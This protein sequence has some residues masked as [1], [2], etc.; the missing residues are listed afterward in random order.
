MVPTYIYIVAEASD[1]N[2]P[3]LTTRYD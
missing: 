3:M 2:D 1:P